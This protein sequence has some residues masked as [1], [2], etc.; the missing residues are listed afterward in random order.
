MYSAL[1]RT[2]V[3]CSPHSRASAGPDEVS[4]H[5]QRP[6]DVLWLNHRFQPS[7]SNLIYV[8]ERHTILGRQANYDDILRL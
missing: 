4:C 7:G 5:S 6:R 2:V 3:V 1:L 8:R